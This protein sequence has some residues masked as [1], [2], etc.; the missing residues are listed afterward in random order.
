MQEWQAGLPSFTPGAQRWHSTSQHAQSAALLTPRCWCVPAYVSPVCAPAQGMATEHVRAA[1]QL[2]QWLME[3]AYN[4]VCWCLCGHILL[5][6][7]H[8]CT[9]AV[10]TAGMQQGRQPTRHLQLCAQEQW[11]PTVGCTAVGAPGLVPS[12]FLVFDA[13][14]CCAC[15]MQVLAAGSKLPPEC[16]FCVDQLSATVR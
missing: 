5:H 1:I 3:G 6:R 10:C 9:A 12:V 7:P 16:S 2:E 8:A 14:V 4:K 11:G 15:C 13:A